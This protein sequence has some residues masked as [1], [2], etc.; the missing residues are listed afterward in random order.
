[1][2]SG[3][4][5]DRTS[6]ASIQ[7]LL[8]DQRDE[9]CRAFD[10]LMAA[11]LPIAAAGLVYLRDTKLSQMHSASIAILACQKQ[12]DAGADPAPIG[13]ALSMLLHARLLSPTAD[14]SALRPWYY[15][16]VCGWVDAQTAALREAARPEAAAAVAC[17]ICSAQ[18]A[19]GDTLA[20]IVYCCDDLDSSDAR[21]RSLGRILIGLERGDLGPEVALAAVLSLTTFFGSGSLFS[22]SSNSP[23]DT[24]LQQVSEAIAAG[25][26]RECNRGHRLSLPPVIV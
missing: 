23:H 4:E 9:G 26:A 1:M 10:L 12:V 8:G 3:G 21:T 2:E 22:S 15:P 19:A 6:A 20:W 11:G 14:E 18:P 25:F 16:L 7:Q 24:D 5:F 17:G 13:I